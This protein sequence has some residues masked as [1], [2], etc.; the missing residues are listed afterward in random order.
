MWTAVRTCGENAHVA[1][2]QGELLPL[3]VFAFTLQPDPGEDLVN[4]GRRRSTRTMG[5]RASAASSR[6]CSALKTQWSHVQ[7]GGRL[8]ALWVRGPLPGLVPMDSMVWG[9]VLYLDVPQ[10]LSVSCPLVTLI[11]PSHPWFANKSPSSQS[12]VFYSSHVCV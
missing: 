1:L 4:G 11:T 5:S 3:G 2:D 10:S 7:P 9:V 12:C 6:R 8:W